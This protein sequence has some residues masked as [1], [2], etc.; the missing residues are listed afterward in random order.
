[1]HDRPPQ[2]TIRRPDLPAGVDD[3]LARALAKVPDERFP[4]CGEFIS[5]LSAAL[6]EP[7]RPVRGAG[8]AG[9]RPS[10]TEAASWQARPT[11]DIEAYGP[12]TSSTGG[13]A[14]RAE[15]P[16]PPAPFPAVAALTDPRPRAPLTPLSVPPVNAPAGTGTTAPGHARH[17]RARRWPRFPVTMAALVVVVVLAGGAF[18]FWRYNQSQYY[19][20]VSSDGLVSVFRGTNQSLAGI[21]MSSLLSESTLKAAMLTEADQSTLQQTISATSLSEAQQRIDQLQTEASQCQATY[22]ELAT[23]QAQ[24]LAYKNYLAAKIAAAKAKQKLPPAVASPGAMPTQLP[25]P[26]ECAPST[27]FG[28]AASAL[29]AAGEAASTPVQTATTNPDSRMALENG[30]SPAATAG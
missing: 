2:V 4:A 11:R 8:L 22:Q 16:F 12:K 28:I 20:G 21:S 26:A 18:G 1:V 25:S 3:V 10:T 24:Y 15:A 17:S 19:V 5:A 27:A 7:P 30:E 29:P 14:G 6:A 13:Q 23:W 9:L